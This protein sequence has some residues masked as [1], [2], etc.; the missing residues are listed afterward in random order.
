M[1]PLRV[2]QIVTIATA[3]LNAMFVVL[4]FSQPSV[5]GEALAWTLLAFTVLAQALEDA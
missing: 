2:I 1:Q 3:G 5:F 4:G